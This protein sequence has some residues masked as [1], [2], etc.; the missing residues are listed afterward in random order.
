M[1]VILIFD[2]GKTNKKVLLFNE[3]YDVVWR[4]SV[5]IPETTDEDGFPCDD[6]PA[7][8]QWID[9]QLSRT[10]SMKE[11]EIVAINCTAYG[12][13]LV[14][15]D[16]QQRPL[17]P[18]YNYLKPYPEDVLENFTSTYPDWPVITAS[19]VSGNLN[20]GLQLFRMKRHQPALLQT[21]RHVCHLPEYISFLTGGSIHSEITSIG[22][23]T[24]M[25]DFKK[26]QYHRWITEEGLMDLLPPLKKANEALHAK[27]PGGSRATGTG[28][29]DSSAA[30]VPYL[31]QVK[32]PFLLL[33]TGTWS[34]S[35]NP[36]NNHPLTKEEL[37][38][39]CLCYLTP[40]GS[41]VKASRLFAGA[42][43][44]Q[45]VQRIAAYFHVAPAY[46]N[47][48][49]FNASLVKRQQYKFDRVYTPG[50]FHERD[51]AEFATQEEAYHHFV[52]DL[53]EQQV[54]ATSY[55]LHGTR[56]RK[57]LVDGG[58][59]RNEVFMHF[60]A[61]AMREY[62]VSAA[63]V[64]EA[65]ALGAAMIIHEHWNTNPLPEELIKLKKIKM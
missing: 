48:I 7:I 64:G 12:A 41:P 34:I 39:D 63:E 27:S 4:D 32:Q 36:F 23:H 16:E 45:Q 13:S 9:G 22:C 46:F 60:F 10:C 18:L 11:F 25:W 24:A 40:E 20:A 53:V 35:L 56:P 59:S 61:M 50:T 51:L 15:L 55:V 57:I 28:L 30:L 8:T 29:H 49:H 38:Q 62:D 26:K 54:V 58:F 1:R 43:H 65:S 19:P 44:E 3:Q 6:L 31:Q 42:F 52:H 17:T 2:I 14:Y 5:S 21:V 33:S 47:T 37:E